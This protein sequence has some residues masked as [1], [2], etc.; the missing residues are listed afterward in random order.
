MLNSPPHVN[1]VTASSKSLM[2]NFTVQPEVGLESLPNELF[3][4]ILATLPLSD[5]GS[6][7]LTGSSLLL[8]KV[9]SWIS[10]SACSRAIV[11]IMNCEE[12]INE[13]G[14]EKWINCC[15]RFGSLCKKATILHGTR[16][17]LEYFSSWY[18]KFHREGLR[19]FPNNHPWTNL[20]VL[21]GLAA[22]L[23][24]FILGWDES[25]FTRIF[26][27]ILEQESTQGLDERSVF[28][29][30]F[31]EFIDSEDMKSCW[32]VYRLKTN[33][34]S[35]SKFNKNRSLADKFYDFLAPCDHFSQLLS[36]KDDPRLQSLNTFQSRLF[37]K[38]MGKTAVDTMQELEPN[39]YE[40]AKALFSDLGKGLKILWNSP[41]IYDSSV[42]SIL[43][44][45]FIENNWLLDN[46]AAC[47]LFS[48]EPV[49]KLYLGSLKKRIHGP[50]KVAHLLVSMVIVCARLSNNLDG[51][52]GNV[53]SWSFGSGD[54]D[55]RAMIIDE[56]WKEFVARIEDG[57]VQEESLIKVGVFV[58]NKVLQ[59]KNVKI[60]S[61]KVSQHLQSEE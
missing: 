34:L 58:G 59:G 6:L 1:V 24:N 5:I 41:S 33:Y 55:L 39:T 25:E 28:K 13:V 38:F 7:C 54:A 9:V 47:L 12:L 46:R 40:E 57:D 30:F 21:L 27:W 37:N 14:Y 3:Y 35:G 20:L 61:S 51:G 53:L 18:S 26:A 29:I 22:A 10:S 15:R 19:R 45:M 49:V 56:L 50:I 52:M 31:W 44:R 60:E 23:S 4:Q 2:G 36:I 48:C 32:L 8:S 42:I 17:R 43:D 11:V 16:I